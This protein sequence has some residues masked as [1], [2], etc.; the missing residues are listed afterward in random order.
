MDQSV[1]FIFAFL[2]I[3]GGVGVGFLLLI[4]KKGYRKINVE[5]YRIKYLEIENSLKRDE[6]SSYQLVILQAD[7]LVEQAM[8]DLGINGNTMADRL[9]SAANKF[10]DLNKL[11]SAHKLRNNIAHEVG[12]KVSYEDAR[13]ALASF[14]RALK[15]L[16][17]I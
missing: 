14:K 16:G 1:C 5:E 10:S 17:A 7:K 3:L 2:I 11:W 15:D 4:N 12:F 13:Y 8:K 9:K 6:P